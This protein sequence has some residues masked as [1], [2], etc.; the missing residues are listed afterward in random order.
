MQHSQTP[1]PV[2][3]LSRNERGVV[4]DCG[5]AA[6][7][8][9]LL[10]PTLVRVRLG[11]GGQFAPRRPWAVVPADESFAPVPFEVDDG[12]STITVRSSAIQLV[13]E[14]ATGRVSFADGSGRFFCADAE[15][16]TWDETG[17]SCTKQIVD[18]DHF[19]GF[20]ERSGPLNKRGRQM[21]NWTTDP[22]PGHGPGSDPLYIAIPVFQVLR[23]G[24][25][26]GVF[27]NNSFR[28]RFDMGDTRPEVWRMWA[29]GGELDYYVAFGP[30]PAAVAAGLAALL[31]TTPMP[32]RWALGYHQS[33]WGYKSAAEMRTL[34]DEFRGRSIPCD[35]LHF[36]IDYMDGYRVFTWNSEQFPD[37]AGLIAELRESGLRVVAIIDPGVKF[38]PNYAVFREGLEQGMFIRK[39]NGELF[40]GYV[41]PDDSVF[42]DYARPEVRQWWGDLQASLV[43]TGVSGIWNDMNEPTVFDRPFSEG[44]SMGGTVDLDAPQGPPQE[45]AT[46]AELHNLY[47]SQMSQAAYEGLRQ[48]LDGQRPF[49]LTRSAFA[50]IQRYSACW[51]GDNNSWWEHMELSMAQLTSMGLSGVPFVGVDI[52]GF[53]GN[54][55][56][57]LW[58]R[59]VQLGALYPFC[60]GHSCAGTAPHEPWVFGPA[61]EA[62]ARDYLSLRYQLLPYLYSLF[63][64]AHRTGAP[65]LRP[66]FYHF[67]EDTATYTIGDQVLLGPFL[68]AAPVCR[69]NTSFRHL[70]LP[71]GDWYDWWSNDLIEGPSDVL[72]HAPLERMPLYVRGGAI[73]PCGPAMQHTD[74]KPLDLLTISV[75]P[76]N[77][78][79]TLYEDDGATLAYEN[80]EF[81]TTA[82]SQRR[83]G[84][85]LTVTVGTREGNFTPHARRMSLRVYA[86]PAG[87]AVEHPN[88]VYDVERGTLTLEW[89]D[90]GRGRELVFRL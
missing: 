1:G 36:D 12:D 59:W 50:G 82:L 16:M 49:V 20:G 10:T 88:G 40:H 72:E 17:V 4:L 54:A 24:L 55:S 77:G 45:G 42:A 34:R 63:W 3:A 8:I 43:E 46:H 39:A 81:C 87:S 7:A 52:G 13:V 90:D 89:E 70:Y 67:A 15:P 29:A 84:E 57:E 33:R 71:E 64:E 21:T 58:A 23:E 68:L 65:V 32:P 85:R 69:P 76:G 2:Q 44:G 6:L 18:D 38:D 41:W 9:S 28:S 19:Y 62:I 26:Y 74:E 83:E 53:F 80:G 78:S 51:M 14:R 37:P 22:Q 11:P 56:G 86:I 60:R 61:V 35:V 30:S 25:A 48:H 31:G 27:F 5:S 79:F 75:F 73:I 47:G 66:L